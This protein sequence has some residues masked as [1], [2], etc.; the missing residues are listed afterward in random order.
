MGRKSVFLQSISLNSPRL[1][2]WWQT[3]SLDRVIKEAE[4]AIFKSPFILVLSFVT[5]SSKLRRETSFLLPSLPK[6]LTLHV[7]KGCISPSIRLTPEAS[8]PG[9]PLPSCEESGCGEGFPLQFRDPSPK[10]ERS[11]QK[12]KNHLYT[13]SVFSPTKSRSGRSWKNKDN[14]KDINDLL[15]DWRNL[16]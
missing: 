1:Q 13:R 7:G 11:A 5:Q 9:F 6:W 16:S 4:T 2:P 10:I 14:T 3:F 8:L 12:K 15:N